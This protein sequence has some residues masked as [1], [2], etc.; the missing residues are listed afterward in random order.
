V[1]TQFINKSVFSVPDIVFFLNYSKSFCEL[2]RNGVLLCFRNDKEKVINNEQILRIEVF[3]KASQVRY[4]FTDTLAGHKILPK[5]RKYELENKLRVFKSSNL[6]ITDRLHAMLFCL[7]TGTPCIAVNNISKKIEGIWQLWLKDF[8][9]I[10]F[11]ES[12][13]DIDDELI[14][15]MLMMGGRI[16]NSKYFEKYWL[17]MSERLDFYE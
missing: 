8:D 11:C 2:H 10:H 15:R 9:Y 6:V 3:L 16:Y 17:E 12:F 7:I 13:C 5:K 1:K 4:D 14:N